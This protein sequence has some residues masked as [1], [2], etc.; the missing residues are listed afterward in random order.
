MSA[1]KNIVWLASYPKSGNTWTRIFLANYLVNGDK[2]VP[3]NQVHRFG[4]GDSVA[5]MYHAVAGRQIDIGD[6]N[7]TLRLRERVLTGI[8]ANRADVNFVKTHNINAEA[9]GVTLI[10]EKFTR[11]AVY[12]MR[13]PLDMLISFARHFGLSHEEAVERIAN[14]QHATP[15]EPKTV[16]QFLGTWSEHVQSW[17]SKKPYPVLVLRY[18]DMLD[19]P[20]ESFGRLLEHVGVPVE[21]ERLDKAI[22]FSSFDE[23]SR[24]E[25]QQGFIEA[26]P[27]AE[28]FF[29]RGKR[30]QWREE[31]TPRLIKRVRRD[32]RKT[33]KKYGYLD[34]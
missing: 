10:P 6:Y 30:D 11:S 27:K 26:S 8:V 28:R 3:I 2:P 13:N 21:P 9:F 18:E 15:A 12:I 16:T 23:L 19:S 4:M 1:P 33:M 7:L 5:K 32:H 14:P 29:A 31:L 34:E 24:Q 20:R 25:E 22:R 17:T